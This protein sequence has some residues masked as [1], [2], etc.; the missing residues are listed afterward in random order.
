LTKREVINSFDQV[1]I[2]EGGLPNLYNRIL[3]NLIL[4]N[5]ARR[6]EFIGKGFIGFVI[7]SDGSVI[8]KRVIKSNNVPEMGIQALE[9]VEKTK[10]SAGTC[11]NKKVPV[12]L[13]MPIKICLK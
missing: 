9:V 5:S 8:G 13:I 1:P 11:G 7:D 3:E 6:L 12:I 4:P 2:P 10:W